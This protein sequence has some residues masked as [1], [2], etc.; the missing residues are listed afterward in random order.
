VLGQLGVHRPQPPMLSR[1]RAVTAWRARSVFVAQPASPP[2]QPGR[3]AQLVEQ[4]GALAIQRRGMP[5]RAAVERGADLAVQGAQPVAVGVAR[6]LVDHRVGAEPAA[7]GDGRVAIRR[8]PH[9]A[10]C[11]PRASA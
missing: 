4:G 6:L 7:C 10:R 8:K 2:A 1:I 5:V 9:H 11:L 3:P